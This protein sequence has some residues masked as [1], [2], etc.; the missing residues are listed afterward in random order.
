MLGGCLHSSRFLWARLAQCKQRDIWGA[1][2]RKRHHETSTRDT[3]RPAALPS[4]GLL[5]A[6]FTRAQHPVSK[7]NPSPSLG[8]CP[9]LPP[10][11]TITQQDFP[12]ISCSRKAPFS[13]AS[14]PGELSRV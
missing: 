12:L 11:P 5:P 9:D 8:L 1:K 6:P 3:A 10:P 2:D 14:V 4:K 7:P 13:F